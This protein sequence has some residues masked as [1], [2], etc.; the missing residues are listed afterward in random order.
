MN[1][2]PAERTS[3]RST[4]QLIRKKTLRG[5]ARMPPRFTNIAADTRLFLPSLT[6]LAGV[7]LLSVETDNSGVAVELYELATGHN[8]V[9]NSHWYENVVS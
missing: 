2:K 3:Q 7:A 9:A 5:P 4:G 8:H 1:V 6:E